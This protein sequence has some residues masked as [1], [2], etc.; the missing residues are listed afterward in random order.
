M[1]IWFTSDTHFHH[2]NIIKYCN[3]PY[4]SVEEMNNA[5]IENWNKTVK[6]NDILHVFGAGYEY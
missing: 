5:L 4:S 1:N 2:K 3:R 6:Q